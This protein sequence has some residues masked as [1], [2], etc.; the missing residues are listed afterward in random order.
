MSI[1]FVYRKVYWTLFVTQLSNILVITLFFITM[2]IMIKLHVGELW[3][4]LMLISI[5]VN[6][7]KILSNKI[8]HLNKIVKAKN[9]RWA[10]E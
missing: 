6:S 3:L 8:Q 1:Y 2:P 7:N 9:K 4:T 10:D 5:I